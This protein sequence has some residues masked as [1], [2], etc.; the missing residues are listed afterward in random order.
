ML[1]KIF[2]SLALC[3]GASAQQTTMLYDATAGANQYKIVRPMQSQFMTANG[4]LASATVDSYFADP[5][6]NGSFS[7]STWRN[8][9]GLVIGANVQ[10]WDTDLDAWALVNPSSFTAPNATKWTTGRTVAM[11][12]DVVYTSGSLDGSGNV[13][14]SANIAASAVTNAKLANMANGTIKGNAS[15]G[16]AAP[17]DLTALPSGVLTSATTADGLNYV[18]SIIVYAKSLTV[19]TAGAPA[20]IGTITLPVRCHLD[21]G[22]LNQNAV[23][24]VAETA[25]GTLA[26]GSFRVFTAA[27]GGGTGLIASQTMPA[28]AGAAVAKNYAINQTTTV[29]P[30]GTVL[31]INQGANSANA[32][33]ASF[34][35]TIF[36]IP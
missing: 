10:A 24:C 15:G 1:L 28:S 21:L 5:S 30:A 3:V 25:S 18:A 31:Y 26:G 29:Y 9:L 32:G 33:T 19:L 11:T 2:L 4:L 16:S 23:T 17:S 12:G 14:G 35:I 6:T 22:T 20:D 7:A 34:Y 13:T 27:A 8:K 36:P